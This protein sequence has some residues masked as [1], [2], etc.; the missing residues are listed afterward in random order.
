MSTIE[1]KHL[2]EG[3]IITCEAAGFSDFRAGGR[4]EVKKDKHGLYLIESGFEEKFHLH[5]MFK[6]LDHTPEFVYCMCKGG[7]LFFK[8]IDGSEK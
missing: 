5:E 6:H 4:Y 7:F 2:K 8:R 3:D 1:Y